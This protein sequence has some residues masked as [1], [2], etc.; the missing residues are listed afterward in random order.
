MQEQE[1][2][3]VP[4]TLLGLICSFVLG[5]PHAPFDTL[6]ISNYLLISLLRHLG[7]QSQRKRGDDHSG[8]FRLYWASWGSGVPL[9]ALCQ[10]AFTEGDESPWNDKEACFSTV[11]V[12]AREYSCQTITWIFVVF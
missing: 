7:T 8:F 4:K 1:V 2:F 5:S 6:L 11:W 9:P 12:L 3:L 10:D